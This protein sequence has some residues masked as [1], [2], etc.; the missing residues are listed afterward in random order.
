M[1]YISFDLD[2]RAFGRGIMNFLDT[3]SRENLPRIISACVTKMNETKVFKLGGAV[4]LSSDSE[5][6]FS[7]DAGALSKASFL[8]FIRS[9]DSGLRAALAKKA[10]SLYFASD[11]K[12]GTKV[13]TLS[14][15]VPLKISPLSAGNF[16][17]FGISFDTAIGI[18]KEILNTLLGRRAASKRDARIRSFATVID[19]KIKVCLPQEKL[20]AVIHSSLPS[21]DRAALLRLDSGLS[22][23]ISKGLLS[24][25]K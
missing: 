17:D 2:S 10:V 7:P 1:K 3:V 25:E 16:T 5:V 13:S 6:F 24:P 23:C 12:T 21:M 22:D 14:A 9:A 4:L 11:K 18:K 19:G 8:H 15:G 20:G